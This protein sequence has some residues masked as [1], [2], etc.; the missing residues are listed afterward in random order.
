[1]KEKLT[2][3]IQGLITYDYILFS[4][5][6]VLFVLFIILTVL[7]RRKLFFSMLFLILSFSILLVGPTLGYV[8]MHQYLFKNSVELVSQK[9]LSFVKAIVVKGILKNE[10][11]FDFKSCKIT[12]SVVKISSNKLKNYI[13]GFKPIKNMSITNEDILKGEAREFKMIIEPFTYTKDYNI[14]MQARCK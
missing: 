4:S 2:A 9:K 6:F 12:A 10:S 3:F 14:T 11:K 7:L 8:K 1:M 5:V 13:Y